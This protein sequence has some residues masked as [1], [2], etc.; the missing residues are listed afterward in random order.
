M[1]K[2][3][4][5]VIVVAVLCIAL[6]VTAL[7]ATPNGT[8][9]RVDVAG[10]ANELRFT[11]EMYKAE[12]YITATSLGS[13]KALEGITDIHVAD[14]GTVSI[15]CGE[16]SRLVTLNTDYTFRSEVIVTDAE[17]NAVDYSGAQGIYKD[18]DG[19]YYLA[20]TN[21]ARVLLF[22]DTG[23]VS[24]TLGLP[25]SEFIASDF[26]YQPAKIAKDSDGYLYILSNGS[27]YGAMQYKPNFEFMG[28]YGSS[29]VEA[30]ALDTLQYLWDKLTSNEIK[31]SKT[32]KKMPY[33]FADFDFDSYD[34]LVTATGKTSEFNNENEK[35]QIRKISHNGAS[36]LYKRTA[37]E[38]YVDSSGI[39]FLESRTLLR[40][41]GKAGKISQ[42]IVAVAVGRNDF[43][44]ALDNT[45]GLVYLFDSESNLLNTFGGGLQAG[46]QM[47]AFYNAV[48]MDLKGDSVLVADKENKSVT[49]FNLTEYGEL[50]MTAQ[51]MFIKGDYL[52]S[53]EYW[54]K[55]LTLDSGNQL[56]YRALAS[57]YYNEG[58][59]KKAMEYA[60][61]GLDYNIYDLSKQE[62]S[63]EHLAKYFGWYLLALAIVVGGVIYVSVYCKKHKKVLVT[64]PK[65]RLLGSVPFHPFDA[66][67]DLKYKKLG[68]TLI[69]IILCVILYLVFFVRDVFSGFLFT[70]TDIAH[71]NS[72]Y[73][74]GK[75][76]GFVLLWSVCY[77]LVS[78]MASG[79]G[80]F[81]EIFTATAYSLVP[82]IVY[83]VIRVVL[84]NLLPYSA[85]GIIG[86]ID[87]V[88]LF[89][90]F[91]LI[92]IGM[93]TV[94]EYDFF[95]FLITA[96][97]TVFFMVLVVFV[98][99]M[100]ALMIAQAWDFVSSVYS[101]I[102]QRQ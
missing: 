39:N 64:N 42:N 2:K 89:F 11:R 43:I 8:Y 76:I 72:I 41:L 61:I 25:D 49:V 102:V 71:Y 14:D 77:W 44:Y 88:I 26:V 68:S 28:F 3:I 47:G 27:Y 18:K 65:I 36:I 59:F 97:V 30:S 31:Q 50:L 86:G 101:E 4:V 95:K 53:K 100:C 37:R 81:R 96:V 1:L 48:A 79:K 10:G 19:I 87:T 85:F 83:S 16:A 6:S 62:V 57:T 24:K 94:N 75:T 91:Y 74:I 34:Y 99:F 70:T 84:T 92:A 58:E 15:L 78:S 51:N 9:T 55:V 46:T 45:H 93:L 52:D 90:T 73:T 40:K 13:D 56:A 63:S 12:K 33:S 5:S 69:A 35:G 32:T 54:E 38:G 82:L 17:G 60:E 20:D 22:D 66:F 21:N 23:V 29:T 98:I 80:T 67:N 7:A